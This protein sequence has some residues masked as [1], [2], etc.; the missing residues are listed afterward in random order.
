MIRQNKMI[1]GIIV[2]G[3]EHKMTQ[4]ADDTELMLEGNITSFEEACKHSS[5]L[6]SK[7]WTVS[8]CGKDH[9]APYGLEASEI[10]L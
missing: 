2:Q 10:H 3:T 4:Y 1:K 6:W 8:K 7:V 5:A 9:A